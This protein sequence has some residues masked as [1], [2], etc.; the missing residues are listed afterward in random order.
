VVLLA[1]SGNRLSDFVCTWP[2]VTGVCRRFVVETGEMLFFK[3][4]FNRCGLSCYVVEFLV[5]LCLECKPTELEN[6]TVDEGIQELEPSYV[7][8]TGFY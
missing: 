6:V 4:D 7:T 2:E 8:Q 5:L 3:F 1:N